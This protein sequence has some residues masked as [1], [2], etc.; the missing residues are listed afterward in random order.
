MDYS[1]YKYVYYGLT[2]GEA[3][4]SK[5]TYKS[6]VYNIKGVNVT[7]RGL[8]KLVLDNEMFNLI[9]QYVKLPINIFEI[10]KDIVYDKKYDII[11]VKIP[12]SFKI[13]N[14]KYLF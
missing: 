12:F 13:Q 9:Y 14:V 5:L 2:V 6:H 11:G 1:K 8:K 3:Q 10:R 4:Q 7:L